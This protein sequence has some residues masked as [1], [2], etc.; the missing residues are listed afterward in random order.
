MPDYLITT[1]INPE[2]E[3]AQQSERIVRA[4]NEA[5]AIRHVVSNTIAVTRATLDDAIRVGKVE[6]AE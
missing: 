6:V 3:T 5:R 1:T 4:K 2:G